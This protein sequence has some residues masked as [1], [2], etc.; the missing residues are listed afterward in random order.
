MNV[1]HRDRVKWVRMASL[2][3]CLMLLLTTLISPVSW[4]AAGQNGDADAPATSGFGA[5][6][7]TVPLKLPGGGAGDL[8]QVSYADLATQLA[9]TG[10]E[11]P[12]NVDSPAFPDWIA[13]TTG[14]PLPERA[15]RFLAQWRQ[16][17]GFDLFQV[18]ETLEIS[19]PPFDLTLY[20]GRFDERA[21]VEALDGL[22]YEAVDIDGASVY[23]VR[24]DYEIDLQSPTGFVLA[25]MN[26]AAILPD[27]TLVFASARGIIESVVAVAADVRESMAASAGIA[28]MLQHLPVDLVG[29]TLVSGIA[30]RQNPADV[31]AL[32]NPGATPDLNAIAT[33][34]ATPNEM[35]PVLLAVVGM[36][37]GVPPSSATP[38]SEVAPAHAIVVLLVQRPSDAEA[39]VPVIK[40]RLETGESLLTGR[41]FTEIFADYDVQAI[42]DEPIVSIDLSIGDAPPN[43]LIMMLYQR[44]LGFV[45]W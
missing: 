19:S 22:G 26:V 41:A 25:T 29:A 4:V 10:I 27:G 34:M 32:V 40:Q 6:L 38:T 44:D 5:M 12:E 36:T 42:S 20:R 45:A 37:A 13:A 7:D 2:S 8:V 30:L 1:L 16:L 28:T 23:A 31:G 3:C 35:P 24:D 43:V 33:E 39:A 21:V 15:S 11:P 18:D 14:M 9:A 17:F